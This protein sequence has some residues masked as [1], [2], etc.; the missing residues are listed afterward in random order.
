MW[1]RKRGVGNPFSN[2]VVW[3]FGSGKA[4]V[5]LSIAIQPFLL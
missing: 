2:H 4:L 3:A 5:A 1:L